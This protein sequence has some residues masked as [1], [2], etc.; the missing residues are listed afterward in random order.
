MGPMDE[1]NGNESTARQTSAV[2]EVPRPVRS[3]AGAADDA[4]VLVVDDQ[5]ANVALLMRLVR[6]AGIATRTR[7]GGRSPAGCAAHAFGHR[8]GARGPARGVSVPAA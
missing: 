2:A 1:P 3:V 4:T 8:D 5:P 7:P 6:K